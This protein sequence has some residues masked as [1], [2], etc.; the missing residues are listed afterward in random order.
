MKPV[1]RNVSVNIPAVCIS[2]GEDFFLDDGAI[3]AGGAGR[4]VAA[5]ARQ[6]VVVHR[7]RFDFKGERARCRRGEVT[8]ERRAGIVK[9]G[10]AGGA[11]IRVGEP[12]TGRAGVGEVKCD[13]RIQRAGEEPCAE[14]NS[15]EG[16]AVER[17][18]EKRGGWTRILKRPEVQPIGGLS[19]GVRG[20][21]AT[22]RRLAS[23]VSQI[24]VPPPL[25]NA[26]SIR[27]VETT[28]RYA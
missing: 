16:E 24:A 3:E 19:W 15:P 27:S 9:R 13:L 14:G 26:R 11:K 21:A 28:F 6:G 12:D 2:A 25:A 4:Q 22:Y 18:R 23:G 7:G 17:H 8:R 1:P 10:L 20:A 5:G